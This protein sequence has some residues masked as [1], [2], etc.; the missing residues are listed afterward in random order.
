M[1]GE[2]LD[3]FGSI[4]ERFFLNTLLEITKAFKINLKREVFNFLETLNA[5][6]IK[7]ETNVDES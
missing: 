3:Y 4:S 7:G 1:F 6:V 2:W 5:I